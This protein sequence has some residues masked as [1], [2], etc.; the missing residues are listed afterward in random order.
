MTLDSGKLQLSQV[1][2]D[3]LGGRHRGEWQADFSVKP[4]ICKGSGAITAVS[5]ADLA[6]AMNDGW[7]AGTANAAYTLAGP[8]P[9]DF[10]NQAE[11]TLQ[12]EMKDGS[13]PHVF[14]ADEAEP[15]KVTIFSGKANLDAGAI[16]IK[17]ARLNSPAGEFQL[18]GGASLKGELD[19]KLARAPNGATAP[20]YTVTGTL[21]APRV[22]QLP[23]PQTQAKLKP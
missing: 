9:A 15:L 19:L 12:F 18:T 10:W 7:I 6:D 14:L 4:A 13:L 21:A 11:G 3:V 17:D 5:L 2:G 8:C 16:E 23:S 20:G 1:T 22:V